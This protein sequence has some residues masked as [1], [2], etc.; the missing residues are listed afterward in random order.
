MIQELKNSHQS[1]NVNDSVSE[2][3]RLEERVEELEE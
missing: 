2:V 1:D 3:R